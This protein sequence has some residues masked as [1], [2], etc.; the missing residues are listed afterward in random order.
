MI[1]ASLQKFGG[2]IT[3][4]AVKHELNKLCCPLIAPAL[5]REDGTICVA[6]EAIVFSECHDVYA[7]VVD[8][9]FKMEPKTKREDVLIVSADGIMNE[10]FFCKRLQ[11]PNTHFIEYIWHLLNGEIPK[12]FYLQ[13]FAYIK[14]NASAMIQA[15]DEEE[16]TCPA[17]F[18]HRQ[19]FSDVNLLSKF[20][21]LL[22]TKEHCAHYIISI[23][24]GSLNVSGSTRAEQNNSSVKFIWE[25]NT[26]LVQIVLFVTCSIIRITFP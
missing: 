3:L 21:E 5:K 17:N 6:C 15:G 14:D 1:R 22:D 13:T 8:V 18:F 9:M 10:H 16:F 25:G 11:F 24:S 12:T 2:Y 7:F 23:I 4:D 26:F 19:V 20:V